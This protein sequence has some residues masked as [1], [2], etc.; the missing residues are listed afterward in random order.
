MHGGVVIRESRR[1][2]GISQRELAKRLGTDQ[3][4][5]GRW[6]SLATSPT[7]EAVSACC[8]ACGFQ[9]DWRLV[10]IDADAERVLREQRS[11]SPA[12]RVAGAANLAA[13][14]RRG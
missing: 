3:S 10:A 4:V 5:I 2:A 1:R 11:R 13:L 8:E 14:R 12:A 9:L 6:E 7:F